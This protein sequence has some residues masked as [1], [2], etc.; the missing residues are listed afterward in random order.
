MSGEPR[1][2]SGE[3]EAT[4]TAQSP[5]PVAE[6]FTPKQP[7]DEAVSWAA[8]FYDANSKE[9]FNTKKKKA[10]AAANLGIEP[11]EKGNYPRGAF[12]DR[13][14]GIVRD[15]P[16]IT[17]ADI[18][19]RLR[20]ETLPPIVPDEPRPE[21]PPAMQP[22]PLAG[23]TIVQGEIPRIETPAT[24][25][26]PIVGEGQMQGAA[27]QPEAV[28]PDIA[29][30]DITK[31]GITQKA[32][33]GIN[34]AAMRRAETAWHNGDDL[35]RA[36]F[37]LDAQDKR[38]EE[39]SPEEQQ[40]A[41]YNLTP[42]KERA[43]AVE[44][45]A[46][47]A[48]KS[49]GITSEDAAPPVEP[50]VREPLTTEL[51]TVKEPLTVAPDVAAPGRVIRES[52]NVFIT[53]S[54]VSEALKVIEDSG[55]A[56]VSRA[57]LQRK[58]KIGYDKAGMLMGYLTES[59]DDSAR[60]GLP[61]EMPA[62]APSKPPAPVELPSVT[63]TPTPEPVAQ[64]PQPK[65]PKPR[66]QVDVT[67]DEVQAGRDAI[68]TAGVSG[69]KR[70]GVLQTTGRKFAEAKARAILER[71][72]AEDAAGQAPEPR[73]A[74]SPQRD[75]TPEEIAAAK[76]VGDDWAKAR[77][78]GYYVRD[79]V[80]VDRQP[81]LVESGFVT[82]GRKMQSEVIDGE[83]GI[84]FA[85]RQKRVP[86]TWVIS[87]AEDFQPTHKEGR[88][89]SRHF[90]ATDW[91][92]NQDNPDFSAKEYAEQIREEFA[93]AEILDGESAYSGAPVGNRRG[94]S[95]QGTGRSNS[96]LYYW[97]IYPNDGK[98]MRVYYK[99]RVDKHGIPAEV[100]DKYKRP[101]IW[102]M[103]DADD[104]K[105]M[106]LSG[107]GQKN[108]ERQR[109]K[110]SGETAG[111]RSTSPE[112][113]ER[114]KKWLRDNAFSLE[115]GDLDEILKVRG[116]ELREILSEGD[117]VKRDELPDVPSMRKRLLTIAVQ[118]GGASA[119]DALGG[120]NGMTAMMRDPVQKV[121]EA[122][123]EAFFLDD[124]ELKKALTGALKL[125]ANHQRAAADAP[126]DT[127][128]AQQGAF[129][130]PA[131]APTVSD[132]AMHALLTNSLRGETAERVIKGYVKALRDKGKPEGM[133]SAE[134]KDFTN[135]QTHLS[136]ALAAEI[137]LLESDGNKGKVAGRSAA[138]KGTRAAYASL[139]NGVVQS[140]PGA[141]MGAM[142]VATPDDEE[143]SWIPG[144]SNASLKKFLAVASI[145]TLGAMMTARSAGRNAGRGMSVEDKRAAELAKWHKSSGYADANLAERALKQRDRDKLVALARVNGLEGE[146]IEL[147]KRYNVAEA[148]LS[149]ENA[150]E[151]GAK[152]L[153]LDITRLSH[154]APVATPVITGKLANLAYRTLD[155][156]SSAYRTYARG[157]LH[158]AYEVLA[159]E[160]AKRELEIATGAQGKNTLAYDTERQ[161]RALLGEGQLGGKPTPEQLDRITG[162]IFGNEFNYPRGDET[163]YEYVRAAR[164][165]RAEAGFGDD[166][167]TPKQVYEGG[168]GKISI[169]ED[170]PPLTYK[171]QGLRDIMQFA[172]ANSKVR[173]KIYAD[174]EERAK[175]NGGLLTAEDVR[176]SLEMLD[177]SVQLSRTG[178]TG[179]FARAAM[180]LDP[181][182][183]DAIRTI[184]ESV[185]EAGGELPLYG[186]QLIIK[187]HRPAGSDRANYAI[188][189]G[190]RFRAALREEWAGGALKKEISGNTRVGEVMDAILKENPDA[191]TAEV[192]DF[193]RKVVDKENRNE[194]VMSY[195]DDGNL[196]IDN[197]YLAYSG[198]LKDVWEQFDEAGNA[199][200]RESYTSE[201]GGQTDLRAVSGVDKSKVEGRAA[202][203]D[204]LGR[205]GQKPS[206]E[207]F[208]QLTR[209]LLR[210]IFNSTGEPAARMLHVLKAYSD[211]PQ[212]DEMREMLGAYAKSLQYKVKSE[213]PSEVKGN[214]G[215]KGETKPIDPI[216]ILD[217]FT[218]VLDARVQYDAK[219]RAFGIPEEKVPDGIIEALKPPKK[220]SKKADAAAKAPRPESLFDGLLREEYRAA[221]DADERRLKL[222]R[223]QTGREN[224]VTQKTKNRKAAYEKD[225]REE[226]GIEPGVKLDEYRRGELD[227]Y[228]W[229]RLQ[230]DAPRKE[231]LDLSD[232]PAKRDE[233]GKIIPNLTLSK[234]QQKEIDDALKFSQKQAAAKAE[235]MAEREAANTD[236][237]KEIPP[238]LPADV[239][240]E[241]LSTIKSWQ[242]E[243]AA[244]AAKKAP[245]EKVTVE[246]RGMGWVGDPPALRRITESGTL[247]QM[248]PSWFTGAVGAVAAEGLGDDEEY[249]GIKGSFWKMF[250]RAGGVALGMRSVRRAG[251]RTMNGFMGMMG[252]ANAKMRL[253]NVYSG[254]PKEVMDAKIA[255]LRETGVKEG[256]PEWKAAI[257]A[258]G[259]EVKNGKITQGAASLIA[260]RMRQDGY[261]Q[262]KNPERFDAELQNRLKEYKEIASGAGRIAKALY[263]IEYFNRIDNPVAA[264]IGRVVT[265]AEKWTRDESYKAEALHNTFQKNNIKGLSGRKHEEIRKKVAAASVEVDYEL[266]E[267]R[268]ALERKRKAAV[269]NVKRIYA[270]NPKELGRQLRVIAA[271]TKKQRAALPAKADETRE[272]IL[273]KHL[274][275]DPNAR[276]KWDE[277]QK[278]M[279][280]ARQI[281]IDRMIQKAMGIHPWEYAEKAAVIRQTADELERQRDMLIE[282]AATITDPEDFAAMQHLMGTSGTSLFYAKQQVKMLEYF[283]KLRKDT[284]SYNYALRWHDKPGEHIIMVKNAKGQTVRRIV[285]RNE[286]ESNALYHE[287]LAEG[288]SANMIERT[289]QRRG[290]NLTQP[291]TRKGV[292]ALIKRMFQTSAGAKNLSQGEAAIL[293]R[294]TPEF[295]S[296]PQEMRDAIT[297]AISGQVMTPEKMRYVLMG[298]WTRP[299]PNLLNRKNI[300]GYEPV[301][302]EELKW[303]YSG[304]DRLVNRAR[305][306]IE[307]QAI[308]HAALDE[309]GNMLAKGFDGN[310]FMSYLDK[311]IGRV[312][313]D[314][315]AGLSQ[316][317]VEVGKKLQRAAG[318]SALALNTTHLLKNV[319][320]GAVATL[321]ELTAQSKSRGFG[322]G[323]QQLTRGAGRFA[324]AAGATT[325]YKAFGKT[326]DNNTAYG[327]LWKRLS[328][329][330][331]GETQY[332]RQLLEQD[333]SQSR[334]GRA[335]MTFSRVSEEFNNQLSAMAAGTRALDLGGSME[336][337]VNAALAMRAAT[338]GRFSAWSSGAL[339]SKIRKMPG[340]AGIAAMSLY[341]ASFRA[342]EHFASLVHRGVRSD[343]PKA[344]G[345]VAA[346]M[347]LTAVGGITNVPL[348]A[349]AVHLWE[350]IENLT[351]ERNE[352]RSVN[353]GFSEKIRR[354][355]GEIARDMGTDA[356]VGEFFYDL[357]YQGGL[358][359]ATNRNFTS[360]ASLIGM[361]EPIVLSKIGNIARVIKNFTD[362]NNSAAEDF[363]TLASTVNTAAGRFMRA[364]FQ[365]AEGETMDSRGNYTGRKYGLGDAFKEGL[366][367]R[368]FKDALAS[369]E[370][371]KKSGGIYDS[372]DAADYVRSALRLPG[373][374]V[375]NENSAAF[376][377]AL[378][379][380]APE[381]RRE[382]IERYEKFSSARSKDEKTIAEFL[383]DHKKKLDLF[384]LDGNTA[385]GNTKKPARLATA[386]NGAVKDYYAGMALAET[387]RKRGVQAN[388]EPA[389]T[390]G[391]N[392]AKQKLLAML[393]REGNKRRN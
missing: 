311:F 183:E 294:N 384:L 170:L 40:Q 164:E 232:A 195:D 85:N 39:L 24:Q 241:R 16:D 15:T 80:R 297:G 6:V 69:S 337:A 212:S 288:I 284:D 254:T 328:D 171:R 194:A 10:A 161:M 272:A 372:Q 248:H 291:I 178:F 299:L 219:L 168:E 392:Y 98:G 308:L 314:P 138:L 153:L 18:G 51:P 255:M 282:Q 321:G 144:V 134:E 114:T 214:Y 226:N 116:K 31:E 285:G 389:G 74:A 342:M 83:G 238:L 203:E 191:D 318:Y 382:A 41:S 124:G 386:L 293:L 52:G 21:A 322:Q 247:L 196:V 92:P 32:A 264:R 84:N 258:A 160:I 221:A 347:A 42:R 13:I 263:G 243:S 387:L 72:D 66:K 185:A 310:P 250:I 279:S 75:A 192:A 97:D 296:M 143:D 379:A 142:A 87:E 36:G 239:A 109:N 127:W 104:N 44:E 362:S 249:M 140:S 100:I 303:A 346:A 331:I 117:N 276:Q 111:A 209:G 338:Q 244:E 390:G 99:K 188:T 173:E 82:E 135:L 179:K 367:G 165:A 193:A 121:V 324:K 217:M 157:G 223:E 206:A 270:D 348:A 230:E 167:L 325:F 108:V 50:V 368:E 88:V 101:L 96:A 35:V 190:E 237:G 27:L 290:D 78:Q 213:A 146:L 312:S 58:M 333:A 329:L 266:T 373:L 155:E 123:A 391:A 343:N 139:Q 147:G 377:R 253:Q 163:P 68:A 94:E 215:T 17:Q 60:A 189:L 366:F 107:F 33:E 45:L 204:F 1:G 148:N 207:K 354:R 145:T 320:F 341:S 336:E 175:A 385:M 131:D 374:A 234:A 334:V 89:N 251:G 242:E 54:D 356:S 375:Q 259:L 77:E 246:G 56:P 269:D 11:D 216:D 129:G 126:F 112:A 26:E 301:K 137:R 273:K 9:Y 370:R 122:N 76:M 151:V 73:R 363:F 388:Y 8:N 38:W 154:G 113:I 202:G 174:L 201:D 355:T 245:N 91:Q 307:A 57:V 309:R 218:Q 136:D 274:G 339:E 115:G 289:V 187:L 353:E 344:A 211:N 228:V 330:D 357:M 93:P 224:S 199:I 252:N 229:Q 200:G 317:E 300:K 208:Q 302:G 3:G 323:V 19:A 364:G 55:G 298:A 102:R 29:E 268:I 166:R 128:F 5:T 257:K 283:E 236:A 49:R 383:A 326:L 352:D 22:E 231:Q 4:P 23:T 141:F 48:G 79:G 304:W 262:A 133:F 159:P 67:F 90:G 313:D 64:S 20:G 371:F 34:A 184:A 182:S 359:L 350:W 176:E 70:M 180:G 46:D 198:K 30:P 261:D 172:S 63:P 47:I 62:T 152:G 260:E 158:A 369:R 210:T 315:Y 103:V 149:P 119:G 381:I 360:D 162:E 150:M 28:R 81:D 105:A 278:A 287:L 393:Q 332:L 53:E 376:R 169:G 306:S 118:D 12:V 43:K 132:V 292:D 305:E 220:L 177:H 25:P 106:T 222:Q 59:A 365:A 125:H 335:L 227:D 61:P 295:A 2:M 280:A 286:A 267:L 86:F 37:D 265:T 71:I 361:G 197:D 319:M 281:D 275:T 271:Q 240:R 65:A 130:N 351:G 378:A 95:L 256:S 14:A 156:S 277:W 358:S 349:D 181:N 110:N 345:M 235:R 205:E 233:N 225:W 327:Q 380:K 120:E 340:G 316:K 186:G 7:P